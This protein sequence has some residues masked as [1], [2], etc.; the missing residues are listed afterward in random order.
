VPSGADSPADDS[1]A[2][3]SGADDSGAEA[4]VIAARSNTRSAK[5]E[6]RNTP[7]SVRH[8]KPRPQ[9]VFQGGQVAASRV[10]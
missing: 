8:H 1:G 6:N 10:L 3:D 7:V 2:D 5:T 9:R 4:A